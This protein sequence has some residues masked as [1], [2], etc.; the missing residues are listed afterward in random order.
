MGTINFYGKI[1]VKEKIA[2]SNFH[3]ERGPHMF[4][5]FRMSLDT[6]VADNFPMKSTEFKSGTPKYNEYITALQKVSL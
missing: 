2:N 3:C 6:M 4:W 1:H 5:Y